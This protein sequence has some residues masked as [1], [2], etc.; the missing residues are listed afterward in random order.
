MLMTIHYWSLR[1]QDLCRAAH[2]EVRLLKKVLGMMSLEL[3]PEKCKSILINPWLLP[4]GIYRR[5]GEGKLLTTKQHLKRQHQAEA[6]YDL[7]RLDFDPNAEEMMADREETEEAEASFPFPLTDSLK[8]LGV[9]I[10][11]WFKLDDHFQQLLTRLSTWE[12]SWHSCQIFR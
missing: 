3:S 1:R 4:R 7:T 8:I 10:D 5:A 9:V 12:W 2:I 11:T 6:E